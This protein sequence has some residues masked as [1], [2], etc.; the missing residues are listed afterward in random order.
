MWEFPTGAPFMFTSREVTTITR[1]LKWSKIDILE[2]KSLEKSVLF[3]SP[4]SFLS[5]NMA[6]NQV[7]EN[8][9]QLTGENANQNNSINV[10][11]DKD[12]ILP[13]PPTQFTSD[14]NA[15]ERKEEN[16]QIDE[17]KGIS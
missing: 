12:Q 5:K 17:V 15:S 1:L 11:T 2:L 3:D 10:E 6:D 16:I 7:N 8:A 4:I 13:T 9:S 14:A